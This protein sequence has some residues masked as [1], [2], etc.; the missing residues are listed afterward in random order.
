MALRW[1]NMNPLRRKT[2][3]GGG[4][5]TWPSTV[6]TLAQT[7]RN[8]GT[9][10]RIHFWFA[11]VAASCNN[12]PWGKKKYYIYRHIYIYIIRCWFLAHHIVFV[13]SSWPKNAQQIKGCIKMVPSNL[14]VAIRSND[15]M[16]PFASDLAYV[17][18]SP[19]ISTIW[20]KTKNSPLSHD[21]DQLNLKHHWGHIQ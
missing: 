5:W 10:P 16:L 21:H 13:I 18:Q 9:P 8:R 3:I 7:S 17:T 4:L 15:I 20:S 19:E 2:F 6:T 14:E 11:P 1:W 12:G